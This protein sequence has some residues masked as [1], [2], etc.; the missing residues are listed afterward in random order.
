MTRKTFWQAI[1]YFLVFFVSNF[2]FY[3]YAIYDFTRVY[4]PTS[5]VFIYIIVWPMFGVFN[6]FVYFR[7]RFLTH[8]ERNPEMS[9]VHSL[10]A[11]LDLG[12]GCCLKKQS[13]E[14][15]VPPNV[16]DLIADDDD[17]NSPLFRDEASYSSGA[18]L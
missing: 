15:E 12:F 6:S 8:R 7:A 13:D 11:V 17:L 16:S 3:I 10:L 4:P 18:N 2:P 1:R 5:I 9:R 14:N